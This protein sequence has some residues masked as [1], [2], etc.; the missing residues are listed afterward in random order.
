[1]NGLLKVYCNR[2][3]IDLV[4]TVQK[5]RGCV[6]PLS[7]MICWKINLAPVE[8]NYRCC[9]IEDPK[10]TSQLSPN[11][12]KSLYV[13]VSTEKQ[14][15]GWLF[16]RLSICCHYKADHKTHAAQ[17]WEHYYYEH[18]SSKW[19]QRLPINNDYS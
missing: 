1:M 10:L 7:V 2:R 4:I 9:N 13:V 11:G 16:A 6:S 12:Y 15:I 3:N 19:N 8:L 14:I 17:N 5:S 18:F